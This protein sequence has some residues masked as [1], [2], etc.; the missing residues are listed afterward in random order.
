M[1]TDKAQ[2]V[3]R[4]VGAEQFRQPGIAEEA[5]K[6]AKEELEPG[7]DLVRVSF[8]IFMELLDDYGKLERA[9]AAGIKRVPTLYL[10]RKVPPQDADDVEQQIIISAWRSFRNF[11]AMRPESWDAWLFF[12]ARNKLNSHLEKLYT[13]EKWMY[14][15]LHQPVDWDS[16]CWTLGKI[17]EVDRR[18]WSIPEIC[19][20]WIETVPEDGKAALAA[21]IMAMYQGQSGWI[22]PTGTKMCTLI[23]LDKSA[24]S[25]SKLY[26]W[27]KE[28][29]E[30]VCRRE[31]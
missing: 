1:D 18:G 22:G 20:E 2:K 5:L 15:E 3:L 28:F 9:F 21:Q 26:R 19:A 12:I 27:W 6:I 4:V 29:V 17:I 25:R 16:Q 24:G 30:E 11:V 13:R 7:Q 23:G 8:E 14:K 31:R 10:L